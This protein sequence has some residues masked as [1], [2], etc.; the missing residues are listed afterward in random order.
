MQ[1]L[2]LI[3]ISN[4]QIFVEISVRKIS[5]RKKMG[6]GQ[7]IVIGTDY[8][9]LCLCWALLQVT[10]WRQQ[11]HRPVLHLKSYKRPYHRQRLCLMDKTLVLSA[12][13]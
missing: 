13:R 4:K 2:G 10:C 11:V 7:L 9:L 8:F 6:L 5:E 3:R 1:A 12:G